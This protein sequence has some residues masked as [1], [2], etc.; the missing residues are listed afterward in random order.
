MAENFDSRVEKILQGEGPPLLSRIEKLLKD[1]G[2]ASGLPS[3]TSADAGKFLR[4]DS[5]GAAAWE[6]METVMGASIPLG[7]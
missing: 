7:N 3:S 1:H 2:T 5:T 4:V 6:T